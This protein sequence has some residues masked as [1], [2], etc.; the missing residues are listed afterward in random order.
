MP[1]TLKLRIKRQDGPGSRSRWEEF[2]VPYRP[3]ANVLTCLMDIQKNP[4][5]AA[6]RK[7]PPVVWESCCLEEVCGA[8]SMVINGRVRQGCSTLVDQL[9]QPIILEPMTKFPVI[10]DL[11]VDRSRMFEALKKVHAWI[12]IDG[13][14]DL[15]P[16]P[17]VAPEV[18]D[19]RYLL[20][21][22]MTCGCCLEACPQ[23]NPNSQFIGPAALSQVRLFNEHPSGKMHKDV[24]LN[25]IMEEGGI[26]D[27]GNAQN[28]VEVCPKEIPLTDSIA[29]L[30]RE[31]TWHGLFGWLK[32]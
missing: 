26:T 18:Q 20:S 5:T 14:Y 23:V 2:D 16:G 8:C 9:S 29:Y 19:T 22:C 17:H 13:T 15:G 3:T 24:R 21:R 27:C 11:M 28:C 10:R 1:E 6:G 4:V 7:T 31:T 30:Y 25:A 32:K 12:D